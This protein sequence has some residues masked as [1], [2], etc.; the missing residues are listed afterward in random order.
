MKNAQS[1]FETPSE[2]SA[3]A[4]PVPAFATNGDVGIFFRGW[5]N[6]PLSLIP[7]PRANRWRDRIWHLA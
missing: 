5:Q 7:S 1:S 2:D 6:L 3:T 4:I